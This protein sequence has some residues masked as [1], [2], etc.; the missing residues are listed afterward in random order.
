MIDRK[1]F[2]NII[3]PLKKNWSENFLPDNKMQLLYSKLAIL[4]ASQ[5]ESVVEASL[6]EFTYPPSLQKIINLA[7]NELAIASDHL[8]Q[9]RMIELEKNPCKKCGNSGW[10]EAYNLATPDSGTVAFQCNCLAGYYK[11]SGENVQKWEDSFNERYMPYYIAKSRSV[12]GMSKSEFEEL[13]EKELIKRLEPV[14]RKRG[15]LP[16]DSTLEDASRAF[17]ALKSE[18]RMQVVMECY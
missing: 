10:L 16:L 13:G 3:L 5:L 18:D 17:M 6:L 9:K 14:L 12:G 1:T 4:T 2:Q 8:R 11:V 7:K 15:I